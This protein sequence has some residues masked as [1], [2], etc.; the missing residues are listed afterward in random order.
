MDNRRI[1]IANLA[2]GGIQ[3]DGPAV[4]HNRAG[5]LAFA[6]GHAEIHKWVSATTRVPVRTQGANYPSFDEAG[7]RDYRWLMER[8]GVKY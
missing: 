4:Y 1:F 5:V 7:R 8:T 3:D 2:K 6:D